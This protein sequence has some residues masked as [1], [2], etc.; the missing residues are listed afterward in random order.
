[1]K[2]LNSVIIVLFYILFSFMSVQVQASRYNIVDYGAKSDK[3][4]NNAQA[5]QAAIDACHKAGGGTVYFPQGDY[6]SGGIQLKS[7]VTL[8][9]ENGA[10]LWAST[11]KLD[12]KPVAPPRPHWHAHLIKADSV[13][14]IAITG[15]GVING[16]GYDDTNRRAGPRKKFPTFRIGILYFTNCKH[17]A[18]RDITIMYS[19]TWT[20]HLW[21]CEKVFIDGVTIFNNYW[22]GTTDGIDP[23]S[24]RDVHISNCH[25]VA[26]DDAIC[27]K[28]SKDYPCENVVITNCILES[29]SCALKLGGVSSGGYR[30]VHVSNCVVRNSTVGIGLYI[31]DGGTSERIT[32]SNISIE[33]LRDPSHIAD[34]LRYSIQPILVDVLKARDGSYGVIRD[35]TFR[36]IFI[37]SDNGSIFQG[38]P[39]SPIENLTLQN[40]TMRVNKG[41]DYAVRRK[42]SGGFGNPNDTMARKILL[43]RKPTYM[44]F[45]YVKGMLLDNVR[46]I[47]KDDVYRQYPRSAV[48][49]YESEGGTIRSIFRQ[50]G[51]ISDETPVINLEDSR[52]MFLTNCFTGGETPVFLE[53]K[54]GKTKNISLKGNDLSGSGHSVKLSEDVPRGTVRR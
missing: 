42:H 35:I 40:V 44:A 2:I 30:N 26:G 41:F 36:D 21:R 39:E 50:A 43:A 1:M 7:N 10:T 18:I 47:V 38:V 46:L 53:V 23:S 22:R 54:G 3:T 13:E 29:V 51:K 24:C 20:V 14:H 11:N 8:Y 16:Q 28:T 6:L 52:N 19:E 5:I 33:T 32:F 34:H 31:K 4:T 25:I 12:Y 49:I 17:V 48:S 27:L 45:G 9:L 37:T 15:H